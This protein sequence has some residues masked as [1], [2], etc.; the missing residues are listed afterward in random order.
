MKVA[1]EQMMLATSAE[2]ALIALASPLRALPG[3]EASY[4]LFLDVYRK[5]R[6]IVIVSRRRGWPQLDIQ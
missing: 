3:M 5:V 6:W 1:R 4:K 2:S